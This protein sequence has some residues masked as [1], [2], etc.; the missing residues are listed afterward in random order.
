M[1]RVKE[2]SIVVIL[3]RRGSGKSLT[4]ADILHQHREIPTAYI[5]APTESLDGFYAG[6]MPVGSDSRI[7]SEYTPEW[8]ERVVARQR[9][10]ITRGSGH[11]SKAFLVLDDVM[12]TPTWKHDPKLSFVFKYPQR[13]KCLFV[14]TLQFP[15]VIP[16]NLLANVDFLFIFGEP[17]EGI[18]KRTY[19]AFCMDVF[20][21]FQLFCSMLDTLSENESLVIDRTVH[22]SKLDT[23]V[24]WNLATVHSRCDPNQHLD[25][26][27]RQQSLCAGLP[28][29]RESP[30]TSLLPP[31]LPHVGGEIDEVVDGV[32]ESLDGGGPEHEGV[33]SSGGGRVVPGEHGGVDERDEITIHAAEA[34]D[35]PSDHEHPR[36]HG[37]EDHAAVGIVVDA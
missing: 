14:L 16:P 1:A 24:F 15:I 30:S 4:V 9:E 2:N 3:G 10:S 17:D 21:T 11:V 25:T 19:E 13:L 5:V 33:R 29:L 12:C 37:L 27:Q 35:V 20:P 34:S 6:K 8:I 7:S 28:S 26:H 31:R 23:A 22:Q 36:G 18:R 32:S